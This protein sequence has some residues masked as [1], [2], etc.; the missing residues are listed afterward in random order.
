LEFLCRSAFL[1][2]TAEAT[3][4]LDDNAE[5][6]GACSRGRVVSGAESSAF[7]IVALPTPVLS[8]ANLPSA[9]RPGQN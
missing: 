2:R 5:Q 4:E 1:Q 3:V 6:F 8:M 9:K 7:K